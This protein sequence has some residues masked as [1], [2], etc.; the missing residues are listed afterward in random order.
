MSSEDEKII[1]ALANLDI[2]MTAH[3][4][5]AD[6]NSIPAEKKRVEDEEMDRMIAE[7]EAEEK[8]R[9]E[10]EN[11]YA[12]EKAK[13]ANAADEHGNQNVACPSQS[14]APVGNEENEPGDRHCVGLDEEPILY[15]DESDDPD[16]FDYPD[17]V[18]H[19]DPYLEREDW[20]PIRNISDD[21][22]KDIVLLSVDP[23]GQLARADVDVLS[24]YEG[25][26]NLVLTL[27][28]RHKDQDDQDY[29][30]SVPSVG[31]QP[32]WQAGDARNL[33]AEVG[34]MKHLF[35]HTTVPVPEV[36]ASVDSVEES[37]LG[38]PYILMKRSPGRRAHELWFED[39]SDLSHIT[40]VR[41]SKET[42]AKRVNMLRSLAKAM[43]GLQNIEFK[44]VGI[45]VFTDGKSSETHH[46]D[47]VSVWKDYHNLTQE[48]LESDT[49][50]EK[51]GPFTS[52]IEYLTPN[53]GTLWPRLH[54]KR[55]NNLNGPDRFKGLGY[56]KIIDIIFSH[57]V[58][59]TSKPSNAE[60]SEE[61]T[62]VLWNELYLNNILVDDD[63]NVT[64][65]LDWDCVCAAPRFVGYAS[66][67]RFLRKDWPDY[68]TVLD[69]PCMGYQL[70]H[71]RQV[72]IKAMEETGCDEARFTAKSGMY[73][74][75]E[76]VLISKMYAP[77][78]LKKI[79]LEIPELRRA[80]L[81]EFAM[82]LGRGDWPEAEEWLTEKIGEVLDSKPLSR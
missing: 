73:W 25:A 72:Y 58:I 32:R 51:Y 81:N 20:E 69:F 54:D 78:L 14:S 82:L 50:V 48:D 68:F 31:T 49:Q 63:G 59:R 4:S 46:V 34:I 79:L 15:D 41:I 45:P 35:Q 9:E 21:K 10:D 17:D 60:T 23:S 19:V 39:T 36:I 76:D 53:L 64:G 67:P 28:V 47:Y 7:M 6:S 29:V 75:I 13:K 42:E 2:G 77:D 44:G 3:E 65:I 71:Y 1:S 56:R 11:R 52:S 37:D 40:A 70:D 66:L 27:H 26:N 30:V 38:A 24:R 5:T 80:E 22:F 8:K 74:A 16:E 62:F 18:S 57:P 33:R 12:D 61:E 55:L 43:A